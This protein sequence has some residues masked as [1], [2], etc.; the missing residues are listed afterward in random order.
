MCIFV[1][2]HI[3]HKN[4]PVSNRDLQSYGSPIES[5]FTHAG[6]ADIFLDHFFQ[7]REIDFLSPNKKKRAI[8]SKNELPT[9]LYETITREKKVRTEGLL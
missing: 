5:H 6:R 8:E 1:Y 4:Q 9:Q 2:F 7:K 3:K